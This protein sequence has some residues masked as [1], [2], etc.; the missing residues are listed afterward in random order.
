[1]A[2][3][4]RWAAARAAKEKKRLE[5][6]VS[7]SKREKKKAVNTVKKSPVLIVIVIAL[8][9]GAVG[10]FFG[11]TYLSPFEMKDFSVNGVTSQEK[12]YIVIDME[13]IKEKYF[14]DH[15]DAKMQEFYSS[16]LLKDDGVDCKFFGFDISDS[17]SIKY[18]YR[19]D[20]SHDSVTVDGID[21]TKAGV[22]YIEYTSTHFVFKNTTLIRTIIVTEV[23]NDG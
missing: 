7:M 3:D 9:L 5:T 10:G 18:Y 12:D 22:Y 2:V 4:D 1:M 11:F 13:E 6:N 16:I 14:L 23:E 15:A 8:I 17:V 20:I 21:L 19:E